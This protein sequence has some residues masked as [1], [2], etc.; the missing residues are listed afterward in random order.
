MKKIIN[1][2]ASV[3]CLLCA[4]TA[5]AGIYKIDFIATDFQ[6]LAYSY[7]PAPQSSIT[8]WITFTADTLNAPITAINAVDLT[9]A[10]HVYSVEE[11]V[12]YSARGADLFFGGVLTGVG[13]AISNTNDFFLSRYSLTYS[14][15]G[16]QGFW[17]ARDFSSSV[18]EV[19]AEVP[20]PSSLTLLLAGAGGLGAML[21]RRRRAQRQI[22]RAG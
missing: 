17:S 11:T 18:S 12:Y 22:T 14:V 16:T 7:A 21:R 5:Q 10:G 1:A 8:G 20:E 9:I 4:A 19:A 13:A 2:L 15:L 3:A 6:P